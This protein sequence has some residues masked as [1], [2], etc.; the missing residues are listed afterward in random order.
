MLQGMGNHKKTSLALF[1]RLKTCSSV[2]GLKNRERRRRKQI[3]CAL[4][5]NS[6]YR[7]EK[8]STFPDLTAA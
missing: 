6:L 8:T 5:S 4:K 3:I 1:I 2:V 7:R